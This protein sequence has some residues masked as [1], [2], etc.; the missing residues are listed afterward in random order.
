M[1][2]KSEISS[3]DRKM[4][5]PWITNRHSATHALMTMLFFG[6]HRPSFCSDARVSNMKTVLHA[7]PLPHL[8]LPTVEQVV[9]GIQ[10]VEPLLRDHTSAVSDICLAVLRAMDNPS[11]SPRLLSTCSHNL[12]LL[13]DSINLVYIPWDEERF[14]KESTTGTAQKPSVAHNALL[15]EYPCPAVGSRDSDAIFLTRSGAILAWY[16]PKLLERNMQVSLSLG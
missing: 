10:K 9:R 2:S 1:A 16:F 13:T 7:V 14:A 4:V 3:T 8:P 11:K 15:Q 6:Q 5:T 12:R